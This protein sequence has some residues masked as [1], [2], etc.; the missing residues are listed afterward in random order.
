[1]SY[2]ELLAA[3]GDLAL[4]VL[5]PVVVVMARI[6]WIIKVNDIPHIMEKI[7]ELRGPRA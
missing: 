5:L 3:V 1:M 2:L 4:V 7:A 6:L